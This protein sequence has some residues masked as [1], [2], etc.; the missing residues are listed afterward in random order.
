MASTETR[1]LLTGP[2]WASD[3]DVGQD[4]RQNPEEL[5]IV[6][7]S[8]FG[9]EYQQR[10]SGFYPP[11]R[12]F[13]QRYHEWDLGFRHKLL[14]GIPEWDDGVN[15]RQHAFSAVDGVPYVAIVATGP[16][17]GNPT[18]PTDSPNAVWRQY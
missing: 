3:P 1:A 5:G 18:D 17:L 14:M 13:N 10:D 2:V 12:V 16:T 11:R 8:G 15:Y 7:T 6:R 9:L 4:N